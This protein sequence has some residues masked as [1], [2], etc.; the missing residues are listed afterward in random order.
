MA[1]T[2]SSRAGGKQRC[3]FRLVAASKHEIETTDPE[4]NGSTGR[5]GVQS[6]AT[7]TVI[8]NPMDLCLQAQLERRK[9]R[10]D[11]LLPIQ[12]Y[13]IR[14]HPSRPRPAALQ[15]VTAEQVV[16]FAAGLGRIDRLL[17]TLSKKA[18]EQLRRTR[19]T[20]SRKVDRSCEL[21]SKMST[22][23]RAWRRLPSGMSNR[24]CE[25]RQRSKSTRYMSLRLPTIGFG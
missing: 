4:D 1:L 12:E 8:A 6:A 20:S 11:A 21:T 15:T 14:A 18:S 22:R 23:N 10:L 24:R 19:K 25:S 9:L 16:A 17:P 7:L 2:A 13:D 3:N 5:T